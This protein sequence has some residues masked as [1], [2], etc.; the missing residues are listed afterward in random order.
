MCRNILLSCL[1]SILIFIGHVD[2]VALTPKEA[3]QKLLEGNERYSKDMLEHPNR[4]QE[5][6]EAIA[7]KQ[8]P[9]AV[10][11]GCSDSRV[12]PEIIFD[13]GIGDI[14]IVRIAGNVIDSVGLASV[15]Y[16][17]EHLH[18]SLIIVLGHENCGAIQAVVSHQTKDIEP[19]AV[20]VEAALKNYSK[21]G[22][23]SLVGAIQANVRGVAAELRKNKQ[24]AD[25]IAQKKVEVVGG[26][27][28]LKSG[29]V[30][31]CCNPLSESESQ[32]SA[33]K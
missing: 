25:L 3:L 13:Q 21:P 30:M 4:N 29:K 16:G 18:S 15:I 10:V 14:F 24:I 9:F 11:V 27:Y 26:Y 20:K 12:S 2:A 1:G 6:R 32:G 19:I 33:K 5:R 22:D 28:E 17:V 31:L 7:A 23:T 8:T